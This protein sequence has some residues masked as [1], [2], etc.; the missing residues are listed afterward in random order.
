P[1]QRQLLGAVYRELNDQDGVIATANLLLQ[2][3]IAFHGSGRDL[4][5]IFLERRPY[6]AGGSFT[7]V[8]RDARQ[9]RAKLFQTMLDHRNRRKAAFAILAQGEASRIEHGRPSGEPRHPMI[10]SGEPWPPLSLIG[11]NRVDT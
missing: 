10:D 1:L 2:S 5:A 3:A 7:F 8:P 9:V 6:G 11:N 4:E